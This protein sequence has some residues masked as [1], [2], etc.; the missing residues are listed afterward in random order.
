MK[1]LKTEKTASEKNECLE[2]WR[3]HK[4]KLWIKFGSEQQE[5]ESEGQGVVLQGWNLG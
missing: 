2:I 3:H 5:T 1:F 4:S